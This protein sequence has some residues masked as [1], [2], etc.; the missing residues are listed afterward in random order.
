M[1]VEVSG[2][3]GAMPD[4]PLKLAVPRGALL[5]GTLDVLD[6]AAV[7]TAAVRGESRALS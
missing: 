6:A 4:G 1:S 7:D 5:S 2:T 3:A